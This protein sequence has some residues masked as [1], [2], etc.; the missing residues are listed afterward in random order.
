MVG[1][2]LGGYYATRVAHDTGCRAVLLNP[3]V[4]TQRDLS[5]YIGEHSAWHNPQETFVFTAEHVAELALWHCGPLLHPERLFAVVA[6]GDEVLDWHEMVGRYPG[7]HIKLLE[8]GDHALSD[9]EQHMDEV[10][11][12]LRLA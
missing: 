11:A 9:F 10:L 1:S 12:F 8:G 4:N 2:S 3:A 5:H 7:S 6:K